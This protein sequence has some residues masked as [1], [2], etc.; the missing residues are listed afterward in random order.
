MKIPMSEAAY[1]VVSDLARVRTIEALLRE[2][3]PSID[4]AIPEPEYVSVV[5]I[6]AEWRCRLFEVIETREGRITTR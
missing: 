2:L 4:A 3:L 5:R 1:I 6:L